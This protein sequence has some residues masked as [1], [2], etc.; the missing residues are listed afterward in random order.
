MK[1]QMK[2]LTIPALVLLMLS[3]TV[4]SA[5]AAELERITFHVA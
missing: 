4:L 1:K 5:H 2:F 3:L